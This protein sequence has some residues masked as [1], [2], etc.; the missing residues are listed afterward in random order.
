MCFLTEKP[1]YKKKRR[2]LTMKQKPV[3]VA[4]ELAR[5]EPASCSGPR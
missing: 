4:Q 5:V 3:T 2:K 1:K